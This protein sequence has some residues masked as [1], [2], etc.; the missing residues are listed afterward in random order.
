MRTQPD[1]PQRIEWPTDG[2]TLS[3]E[4]MPEFKHCYIFAHLAGEITKDST[5][6]RRGAFK[7]KREGYAL[8]KAGHVQKVQ[9]NATSHQHVCF[10]ESKVKASMTKNKLYRTR[11]SLRKET[12]GVRSGYCNCKAGATG[13]CKHVGA[14]L[15]M[16]LDF[17]E[18][19]LDQ[20]PPDTTCTE[21]PQQWHKPRSTACAD[22]EA[23][24]LSNLLVIKHSYE[25]DKKY[26]RSI[27]RAQRKADKQSFE[28]APSFSRNVTK[29]QNER[30]CKDLET[31]RGKRPMIIDLLKTTSHWHKTGKEMRQQKTSPLWD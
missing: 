14:L 9:F 7:S 23:I 20:I 16:I 12:A 30:L 26:D 28:A 2:W 24:L 18:S 27:K 5:K 15:F 10:F 4:Q 25:A 13:R 11:V 31:T 17:V 21:R 1:E 8:F 3:L 19:E 22:N 6:F 29:T